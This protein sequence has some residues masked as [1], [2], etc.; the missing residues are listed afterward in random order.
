MTP[1]NNKEDKKLIQSIQDNIIF[2]AFQHK[3]ID[4]SR[5]IGGV[6]EDKISKFS[7]KSFINAFITLPEV[8]QD[9]EL[10]FENHF[11][12][13]LAIFDR[14]IKLYSF[15]QI[16]NCD[17]E[18]LATKIYSEYKTQMNEIFNDMNK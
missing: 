15:S 5:I 11:K 7:L 16:L 4:L 14:N 8:D 13:L 17:T 18:E 2:V 1:Q 9:I 12:I 6:N 10:K 3:L